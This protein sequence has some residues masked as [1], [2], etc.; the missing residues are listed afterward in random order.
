MKEKTNMNGDFKY[1]G[2]NRVGMGR[3]K[4]QKINKERRNNNNNNNKKQKKI[5]RLK[6]GEAKRK[7][8]KRPSEYEKDGERRKARRLQ[9]GT[10]LMAP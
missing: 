6:G 7:T 5:E 9:A 2:M 10:S 1:S 3:W 8:E 4:R